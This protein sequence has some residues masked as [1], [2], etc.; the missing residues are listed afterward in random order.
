MKGSLAVLVLAGAM[1]LPPAALADVW[2]PVS[3]TPPA[4][5]DHPV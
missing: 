5:L 3:G 1:L 2:E 4:S